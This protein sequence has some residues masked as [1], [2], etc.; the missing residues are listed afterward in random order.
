MLITDI[1]N[2]CAR[3]SVS[4]TEAQRIVNTVL[5]ENEFVSVWQNADW[6]RDGNAA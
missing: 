2:V 5:S 3:F 1:Y 6:W 4:I